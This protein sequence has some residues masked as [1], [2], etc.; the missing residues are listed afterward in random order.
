MIIGT[1]FNF[2]GFEG[3]PSQQPQAPY[4]NPV[5][6]QASPVNYSSPLT[7]GAPATGPRTGDKRN[8]SIANIDSPHPGP[9]ENDESRQAAEEDKRR[10]NTAASAR[11]R[12][13]KKQ[14]EQALE[15]SAKE[16]QEKMSSLENKI[17]QLETEN[18]WLKSLVIEKKDTKSA[19]EI[20]EM[21]RKFREETD[22]KEGKA[23]EVVI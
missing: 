11:F 19:E 18:K 16:M 15:K 10:R 9:Y 20:A 1:D 22:S 6:Y 2:Q 12:V 7:A 5:S 3:L 21:Y 17:S 23:S 8:A 13:K 4:Q 14:K